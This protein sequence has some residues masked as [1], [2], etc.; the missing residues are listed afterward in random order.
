MGERSVAPAAETLQPI[1]RGAV[2]E[3]ADECLLQ[4]GQIVGVDQCP[5][6]DA[7]SHDLR[8]RPAEK[9]LGACGPAPHAKRRVP[10]DDCAGRIVDDEVELR[11][12]AERIGTHGCSPGTAAGLAP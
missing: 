1:A 6:V 4:P 2:V 9:P 11:F 7:S 8:G 5:R 10:L 12:G 3:Q